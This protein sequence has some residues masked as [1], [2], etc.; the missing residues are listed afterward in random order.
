MS[1]F[2][3]AMDA[4]DAAEVR[5]RIAISS[6]LAQTFRQRAFSWSIDTL[7]Y[8][9]AH[10]TDEV[11][12]IIFE[13]REWDTCIDDI[14][15]AVRS[16]HEH[17]AR[18]WTAEWVADGGEIGVLLHRLVRQ[19][20][21]Q[22]KT[23]FARYLVEELGANPFE[24]GPYWSSPFEKS[25]EGGELHAYFKNILPPPLKTVWIL[26]DRHTVI[27]QTEN[28]REKIQLTD[29]FNFSTGTLVSACTSKDKQLSGGFLLRD[30]N[31]SP[32]VAEARQELLKQGGTIP[33]QPPG[34][35]IRRE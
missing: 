18:K 21:M 20:D 27:R 16:T 25:E 15:T 32:A 7:E 19:G 13:N 11:I 26:V 23:S 35:V 17:L 9:L 29:V 24:T 34:K 28:T 12:E 4:G 30:L 33:V 5:R 1:S 6:S 8:A 14:L 2:Q 3:D 31:D 10:S 22:D